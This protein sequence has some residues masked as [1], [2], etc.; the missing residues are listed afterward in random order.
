[1]SCAAELLLSARRATVLVSMFS[2]VSC[3]VVLI[4]FIL[5]L[6]HHSRLHVLISLSSRSSGLN[7]V[8]SHPWCLGSK[9][10]SDSFSKIWRLGGWNRTTG[11]LKGGPTQG[12]WPSLVF[13]GLRCVFDVLV[14]SSSFVLVLLSRCSSPLLRCCSISVLILS[15]LSHALS[16]IVI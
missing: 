14:W 4:S 1:M 9:L 8:G 5:F 13:F 7:V 6:S 2:S 11:P 15:F 3:A 16:L 12:R 10:G